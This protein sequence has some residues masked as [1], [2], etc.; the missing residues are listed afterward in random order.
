MASKAE[1]TKALE[2]SIA[3]AMRAQ[4]GGVGAANAFLHSP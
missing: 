1:D 2:E 4:S 3:R